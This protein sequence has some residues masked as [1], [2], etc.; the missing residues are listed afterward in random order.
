MKPSD[1]EGIG[2]AAPDSEPMGSSAGGTPQDLYSAFGSKLD[3]APTQGS[4]RASLY[5]AFRAKLDAAQAGVSPYIERAGGTAQVLGGLSATNPV[6]LALVAKGLMDRKDSKDRQLGKLLAKDAGL[7]AGLSAMD[8]PKAEL[9]ELPAESVQYQP[10][11]SAGLSPLTAPVTARRVGMAGPGAAPSGQDDVSRTADGLY[12]ARSQL[13]ALMGQETGLAGG[14]SEADANRAEGIGQA[15][16]QAA[17]ADDARRQQ[18]MRD[19][20]EQQSM[21]KGWADQSA[22]LNDQLSKA[23]IDP[24]HYFA[25]KSVADKAAMIFGAALGGVLRVQPGMDGRN[26]FLEAVDKA[27]QDDVDAQEKN[28]ANMRASLSQRDNLLGQYMKIHGNLNA[29]K[30]QV[31]DQQTQAA[32]QRIQGLM[33]SSNAPGIRARGEQM[34]NQLQQRNQ[35]LNVGIAQELNQQAIA[36]R[37]AQQKAAAAAASAAA[38]ARAKAEENAWQRA[39]QLRD[40]DRKNRE[41]DIKERGMA[42]DEADKTAAGRAALAKI[43]QDN[44]EAETIVDR[45]APQIAKR[46]AKGNV[47]RN[48]RGEVEI[49]PDKQLEGTGRWGKALETAVEA[50]PFLPRAIISDNAKNNRQDLQRLSLAYQ[51]AVT[52]AGASEKEREMLTKAFAGAETSAEVAHAIGMAREMLDR[53]KAAAR[54]AAGAAATSDYESS[55]LGQGMGQMPGSF[56]PK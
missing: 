41:L 28:L 49:D 12:D 52:G 7:G 26:H 9:R 43:D 54:A 21:L 2:D 51:Q 45:L 44:V 11:Q 25:N 30:M 8:A 56:R 48:G 14:V 47:I 13:G 53:K 27:Q 24:D 10:R 38:S 4:P 5:D 16:Q 33:E 18:Y 37:M 39:S 50:S 34:I 20:Q 15:M 42:R 40:E 22:Q 6:G 19:V 17:D 32:I 3:A 46:D 55:I 23:K 36:Q 35:Q 31:M 29:A 1:D